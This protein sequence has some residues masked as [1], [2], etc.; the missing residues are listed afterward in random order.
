VRFVLER[1]KVEAQEAL[2]D[3]YLQVRHVMKRGVISKACE[4]VA[5]QELRDYCRGSS[6]TRRSRA[7]SSLNRAIL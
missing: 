1:Y 2:A 5:E 7:T 3:V 6:A 4:Q